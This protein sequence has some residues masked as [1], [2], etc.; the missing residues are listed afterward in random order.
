MNQAAILYHML[1]PKSNLY[2][3][4]ADTQRHWEEVVAQF[5]KDQNK[6]DQ[7]T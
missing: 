3:R 7:R 4:P 1:F 6:N 2:S 5:L